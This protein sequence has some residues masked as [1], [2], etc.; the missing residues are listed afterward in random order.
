MGRGSRHTSSSTTTDARKS[1]SGKGITP[2]YLTEESNDFNRDNYLYFIGIDPSYSST[3]VVVLGK[4]TNEPL[5]AFTVRAGTS[6]NRFYDRMKLAIDKIN[7]VM[8]KYPMDSTYVVMEGGAFASEF[9][10]F[11]LGKLAGAFE[12][13]LGSLGVNYSLVA[14]TYV[15]KVATGKGNSTKASVITAVR[16]RWEFVSASDDINDAYVMAQIARGVRNTGEDVR[17]EKP[18]KRRVYKKGSN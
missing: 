1:S 3:G 6:T 12:Y 15:K 9:V 4:E 8:I 18:R 5:E 14:P 11:K 7:E 16:N 13:Y 17:N 2:E 10:T